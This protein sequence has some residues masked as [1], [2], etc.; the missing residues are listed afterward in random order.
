M[1]IPPAWHEASGRSGTLFEPSARRALPQRGRSPVGV[2]AAGSIDAAAIGR[3]VG[4]DASTKKGGIVKV[5]IGRDARMHGAR[6]GGSMGLTTWAAFSGS[7]ALAAMDGDFAMTAS[8]VQP[9]LRALRKAGIHVVALHNHM[10][11]EKPAY[12]FT[13]FWGKGRAAD[14]ARAFRAVLDAQRKAGHGN[15]H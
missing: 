2:P 12:Y 4:A 8:E 5:T 15:G 3:I 11:G 6:F 1:G 7:D 9:V 10:I 14:L 13:H